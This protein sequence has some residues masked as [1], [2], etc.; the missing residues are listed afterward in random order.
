MHLKNKGIQLNTPL[1]SFRAHAANVC[2][3]C[4]LE[5]LFIQPQPCSI[6][7]LRAQTPIGGVYFD[8]P[9]LLSQS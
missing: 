4:T 5:T 7:T 3:C 2:P 9:L 8:P 6:A 1:F